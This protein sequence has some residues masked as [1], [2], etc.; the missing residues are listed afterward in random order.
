M[1]PLERAGYIAHSMSRA[2]QSK[3]TKTQALIDS[4][5]D[6]LVSTSWGKDSIVLLHVAAQVHDD[7][8][9]INGRYPNANERLSESDRVR[10]AI[11][12]R[13]DMSHIKYHEVYVNGEW[14]MYERA[15]G[16]FD[17]PITKEQKEAQRWWANGFTN[18]MSRAVYDNNRNGSF[19][20]MRQDESHARRMNIAMRGNDYQ[21]KDG[22]NICLPL[23]HWTGK[24]IWAY[25]ATNNLPYLKLYDMSSCGR[26]R[27]RSEFIFSTSAASAAKRHGVWEDWRKVYPQEFNAWL[28][29]FPDLGK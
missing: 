22:T 18:N 8:I 1:M 2:Y 23:A 16:G 28:D 21:K 26:E 27:T 29:K 24:D 6:Y 15:G 25:I 14:E 13:D 9:A 4:H 12:A 11:L 7:L 20:G 19:L 3:L 5:P 17:I 10:D